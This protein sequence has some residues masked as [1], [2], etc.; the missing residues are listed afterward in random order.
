MRISIGIILLFVIEKRVRKASNSEDNWILFLSR[1]KK[2]HKYVNSVIRRK[3]VENIVMSVCKEAVIKYKGTSYEDIFQWLKGYRTYSENTKINAVNEICERSSIGERENWVSAMLRDYDSAKKAR[4]LKR[5]FYNMIL[6]GFNRKVIN[7]RNENNNIA[8]PNLST[9][10]LATS[11]KCNLDCKG[12]ESA[13]ERNGDDATYD[14]L[15]YILTQAKRLNIFHVVITGKGEPFYNE[16]NKRILFKLIKAHWDLNFMLITNCTTLNEK[17]I[18]EIGALENLITLVSIDGIAEINDR[19][20]GKGV[21]KAIVETLAI[22]KKHKLLYGYSTTVYKENYR[23]ILSANFLQNM[24]EAGCKIGLYLMFTPL[25]KESAQDMILNEHQIREYKDLYNKAIQSVSIPLLDPEIFE[26]KHGCRAKRG[27][28]IYIDG[29]TGKVMPCVKT[30]YSP[31]DCNIYMNPNKN[32]LLEIL[33]AEYFT[34]YRN[35]YSECSQCSLNPSEQLT[36]Y[37]KNPDL[38]L[39]DK[40]KV[41]RYLGKVIS[42]QCK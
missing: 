27:S 8:V 3:L 1:H 33:R 40:E 22:M 9:L 11:N 15:D 16:A 42:N 31:E 18:L 39:K 25:S 23:N 26:A 7:A 41:E 20:R 38:S 10:L 28:L 34:N 6:N 12:C 4:L 30:P 37:L 35:S 21:F 14:Q 17:D 24:I 29:T 2:L 5:L 32:R 19:R 13:N 36:Q